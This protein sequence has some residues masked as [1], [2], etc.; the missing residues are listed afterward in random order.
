VFVSLEIVCQ[1]MIGVCG[2]ATLFLVTAK[3]PG[4]R[5]LASPMG[6]LAQPFWIYTTYL[7]EQ[8]GVLVLTMIYAVRWGQVFIREWIR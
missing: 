3:D 7:H 2:L 6:L 4:M 5:K 1:V 8:W